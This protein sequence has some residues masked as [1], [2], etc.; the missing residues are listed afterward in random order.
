MEDV[1]AIEPFCIDKRE[2][3]NMDDWLVVG[4][5]GRV[6]AVIVEC[7]RGGAA[8]WEAE[9]GLGAISILNH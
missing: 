9:H 6:R 3:G 5:I 7:D 8:K 4:E 2:F 1:E